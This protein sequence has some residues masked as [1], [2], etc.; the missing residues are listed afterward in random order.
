[1]SRT[2]RKIEHAAINCRKI[3]FRSQYRDSYYYVQE[4]LEFGFS[5]RQRDKKLAS[6]G[7]LTNWD[8]YFLS[9]YREVDYSDLETEKETICEELWFKGWVDYKFIGYLDYRGR[10]RV[11]REVLS[12]RVSKSKTITQRKK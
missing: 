10:A 6:K 2:Y 8:D 5:P 4:L 9:A 7:Y 11:F 1:M 3:R 12:R